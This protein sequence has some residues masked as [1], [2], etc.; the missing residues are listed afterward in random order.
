MLFQLTSMLNVKSI[1]TPKHVTDKIISSIKTELLLK[2][3]LQIH[4]SIAKT[5]IEDKCFMIFNSNGLKYASDKL[6]NDFKC[7]DLEMV[8][9]KICLELDLVKFL[10]EDISQQ[11][12]FNFNGSEKTYNITSTTSGYNGDIFIK[13]IIKDAIQ[14]SKQFSQSVNFIKNR[15]Y[16]IEIIKDKIL[17]ASISYSL[18]SIITI[19]VEN[20]HSL[21][22]YWNEYEI[23]MAIRDL[24][25]Q[26]EIEIDSHTLLAQYDNNLY[27]TL[28][29]GLDFE[30]TKQKATTIQNK[31]S[32]YTS[33]QSIKPIIGIYAFDI[34]NLEL[35]TVLKTISDI[36][37]EDISKQDI[38]TEK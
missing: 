34:N 10:E 14:G 4:D 37:K 19:Q 21:R 22:Q 29:E 33:K 1:I 31:I 38:E 2:R 7:S 12:N 17:E 32:T 13:H 28:F 5:L 8:K 30:A 15:I 23:E 36:S 9:S 20:M 26:V 3:E 27:L 6:Y 16:F 11:S 18:F 25:L 24:L 35:D